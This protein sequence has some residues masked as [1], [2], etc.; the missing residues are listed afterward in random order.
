MERS[1]VSTCAH[2]NELIRELDADGLQLCP[3]DL[4]SLGWDLEDLVGVELDHGHL[5][6]FP[7]RPD[8]FHEV[9]VKTIAN[10]VLKSSPPSSMSVALSLGYRPSTADLDTELVDFER[11]FPSWNVHQG[12]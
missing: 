6:T 7:S 1:K 5:S 8:P 9:L 2:S 4:T 11:N 10:M 12:E 3:K